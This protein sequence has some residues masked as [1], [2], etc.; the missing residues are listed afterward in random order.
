[1]TCLE[2]FL[3]GPWL[4]KKNRIHPEYFP[5]TFHGRYFFRIPFWLGASCD[6]GL[7]GQAD[8]TAHSQR[9]GWCRQQALRVLV[10]GVRSLLCLNQRN[11]KIQ[12]ISRNY[13]SGMLVKRSFAAEKVPW[14][15]RLY[16]SRFR[17]VVRTNLT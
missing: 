13:C 7:A 17:C 16:Q 5:S 12:S 9:A 2:F 10:W 15:E 11:G 8:Y 6:K 1:P 3:P 4:D 14:W